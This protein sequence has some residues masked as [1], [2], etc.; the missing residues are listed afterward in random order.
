MA[1]LLVAPLNLEIFKCA[2]IL[3]QYKEVSYDYIMI[4]YVAINENLVTL[5]GAMSI[6][7]TLAT[8]AAFMLL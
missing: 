5:D 8:M 4:L 1:Y 7:A 6:T 2:N 3:V